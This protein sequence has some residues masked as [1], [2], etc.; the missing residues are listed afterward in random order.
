[1]RQSFASHDHSSSIRS[2][3]TSDHYLASGATDDRIIIYDL[4]TRKEHCMLTH[5]N[6]TIN[7]IQFINNHSHII[8]G[9]ADGVLAIVRVGNWQLEK[10]WEK[11]HNGKA[12]LDIA[13]HP[14]GKLALTLGAD[15]SL[16]TWNLVKGR[17]AYIINLNS[18]SKDPRSLEKILW[19]KDE[20]HFI[21]YGGR[22]TEIWSIEIGGV[23]KVIEHPNKV[24]SCIWYNDKEIIVGYENGEL[25]RLNIVTDS[26]NIQ[27]CHKTR[28]KALAKHKKWIVSGDSSGEIKVWNKHFELQ[29]S[30]NAG[31]R[32]TCL[33]IAQ[34]LSPEKNE[35]DKVIE[36]KDEVMEKVIDKESFVVVELEESGDDIPKKDNSNK[37]RKKKIEDAKSVT[38]K[39]KKMVKESNR[40][41]MDNCKQII[42]HKQK[43]KKKQRTST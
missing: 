13:V 4:K 9:S 1:M 29:A 41:I 2:V 19:A 14:S 25:A 27:V 20:I 17:Q 18:K 40:E 35:N 11:A 43:K 24:C 30:T 36:C 5:H 37:Q 10:I 7:C 42:L 6:S 16:R 12:I 34:I 28:V 39:K 38:K 23:L 32:I 22:Y 3:A 8:S 15:T 26:K 21:L 33:T 31:C